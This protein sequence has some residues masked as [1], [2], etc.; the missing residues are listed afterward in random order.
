M[1]VFISWSGR[2]SR[3]VASAL[4]EY[5]PHVLQHVH[6][7]MSE[8]DIHAGVR[9]GPELS[10]R[11]E[12]CNFGVIVLTPENQT[13]PWLLFEAGALSKSIAK[14]RV[15]PYLVGIDQSG[16]ASPLSQFQAVE[17]DR[18]GTA[19]LLT[20]IDEAS[21]D[22]MTAERVE[23]YLE[24]WWSDLEVR[25]Q[26]ALG[27]P[28]PEP[29]VQPRPL[30]NVVEEVLEI[31]RS[32]ARSQVITVPR[33]AGIVN[34][35]VD[36]SP[37]LGDRGFTSMCRLFQLQTLSDLV[38]WV[39]SSIRYRSPE[40]VTEI[41][42]STYGE[43]WVIRDSEGIPLPLEDY[44]DVPIRVWGIEEGDRLA[45]TPARFTEWELSQPN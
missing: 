19:S 43:A 26:A 9:W 6:P 8:H 5:L 12:E 10:L 23:T 15:V 29:D 17:A 22:P 7:W 13:A 41:S 35:W 24:K 36:T 4:R 20:S 32:L 16:V 39:A 21:S 37:L 25:I 45:V 3:A 31:V 11:L 1:E 18:S 42:A 33:Q 30:E 2:R 40:I 34:L 14:S 27:L 44:G 38:Q 28:T